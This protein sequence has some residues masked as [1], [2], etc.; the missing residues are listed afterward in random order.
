MPFQGQHW[1]SHREYGCLSF[2]CFQGHAIGR[3]ST[4][5]WGSAQNTPMTVEEQGTVGGIRVTF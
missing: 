2:S 3:L 5:G 4:M 1:L